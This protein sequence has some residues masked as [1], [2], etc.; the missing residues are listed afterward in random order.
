MVGVEP[1]SAVIQNQDHVGVAPAV[2]IDAIQIRG[3]REAA[4]SLHVKRHRPAFSVSRPREGLREELVYPSVLPVRPID[5]AGERLEAAK[6]E[7]LHLLAHP[8]RVIARAD[9]E[10]PAG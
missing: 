6:P 3:I 2:S 5:K 4:R 7:P 10:L 9:V 8:F 1:P